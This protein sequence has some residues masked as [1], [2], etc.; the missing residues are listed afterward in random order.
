MWE[1]ELQKALVEAGREIGLVEL[2]SPVRP[3]SHWICV[4]R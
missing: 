1:E 2:S 4:L 3:S